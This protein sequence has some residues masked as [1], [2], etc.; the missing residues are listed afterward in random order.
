MIDFNAKD[1]MVEELFD[2]IKISL[3][4]GWQVAHKISTPCLFYER[5][6]NLNDCIVR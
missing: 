3:G 4:N 2:K 1:V 5:C 6:V